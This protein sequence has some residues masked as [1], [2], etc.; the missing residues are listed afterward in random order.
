M[1]DH[2]AHGV[3]G[4]GHPCLPGHF[5]GHAVV[6]AVVL[7]DFAARS[8]GQA[9]GRGVRIVAIPAVKFLRPCLPEQPFSVSLQIDE[10][11]RT[12]RFSIAGAGAELA[13][14]RFEYADA[15]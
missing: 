12:A 13:N 2:L 6:P 5:P 14:G 4:A 15:A 3:I 8:L 10:A 1:A 7:L 11:A 9:L